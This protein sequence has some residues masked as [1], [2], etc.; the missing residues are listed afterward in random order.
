[1]EQNLYE[2]KRNVYKIKK[3]DHIFRKRN[4]KFDGHIFKQKTIE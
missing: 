1:M 4:L 2:R 3:I